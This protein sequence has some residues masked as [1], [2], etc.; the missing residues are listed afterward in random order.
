MTRDEFK[1]AYREIRRTTPGLR[2]NATRAALG[3]FIGGTTG[4]LYFTRFDRRGHLVP[5]ACH[6]NVMQHAAASRQNRDDHTA[7]LAKAKALRTRGTW[8]AA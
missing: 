1:S 4:G 7:C 5:A 6:A 3:V 8:F 2:S